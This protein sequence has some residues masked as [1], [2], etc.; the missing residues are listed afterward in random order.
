MHVEL[1]DRHK[2]VPWTLRGNVIP[3]YAGIQRAGTSWIPA[4]A[5]MTMTLRTQYVNAPE[6]ITRSSTAGHPLS[7]YIEQG[8]S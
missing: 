3:A 5:G 6:Y 2:D 7:C 8:E 1:C 4:C